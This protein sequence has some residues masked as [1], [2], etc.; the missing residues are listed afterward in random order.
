VTSAVTILAQAGEAAQ[1]AAPAAKGWFAADKLPLL[2]ALAFVVTA[3]IGSIVYARRGG[4]IRIRRLAGLDAIEEAVGRATEMGRPV[5]FVPGIQDMDNIMTVAGVTVLGHVSKVTAEY[6]AELEVPTSRS[7]VMAAARETVQSSYLAAGRADAYDP[8]RIY[9][10]TD[11]QFS[12][13]AA[14]SGM[15]AR[16]RPAACFYFGCFFA[17]SLILAEN[18]NS[19]GAIQVAGTAET[20]QLPFFVASC[21]YT[22]IGEEFFAAS[23]YLSGEPDQRGTLLGQDAVK[24]AAWAF[25]LLA[26][27][28]GTMAA[29]SG[30][31]SGT[32]EFAS[33]LRAAL[34]GGA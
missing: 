13:V 16:K 17:E 20:A 15:M 7:I 24:A 30:P 22:L 6:D 34:G 29:A 2:I 25:V 12:Y 33:W 5:L 21:D 14:V 31:D 11:D 27:V 23:A 18:G 9:Y 1:A 8:D 28:L 4:A 26:A 10:V 3:I 32:A 19:I